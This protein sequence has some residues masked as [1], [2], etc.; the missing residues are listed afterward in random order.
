MRLLAAHLAVEKGGVS[1]HSL[2]A[3]YLLS[4]ARGLLGLQPIVK[5]NLK[6]GI[7]REIIFF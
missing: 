6:N 3:D 5:P 4:P 2:W 1:F 7:I